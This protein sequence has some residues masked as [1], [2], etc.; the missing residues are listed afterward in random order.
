MPYQLL[1]YGAARRALSRHT[2]RSIRCSV[3]T[4]LALLIQVGV[5]KACDSL[6]KVHIA[7]RSSGEDLKILNAEF[8]ESELDWVFRAG[9][10]VKGFD[11][12]GTHFT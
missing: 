3:L 10:L 9:D 11:F 1:T 2:T 7:W 5:V 8:L 4:L 12:A 6:N